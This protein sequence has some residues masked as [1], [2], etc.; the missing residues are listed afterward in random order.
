MAST[1]KVSKQTSIT[2]EI[3]PVWKAALIELAQSRSLS[4]SD[5]LRLTIQ[6]HIPAAYPHWDAI[7]TRKSRIERERKS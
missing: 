5:L 2:F 1:R 3:D 4:L 6:D 7:L